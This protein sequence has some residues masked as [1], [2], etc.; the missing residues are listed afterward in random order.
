MKRRF[1]LLPLLAVF[2]CLGQANGAAPETEKDGAPLSIT[3]SVAKDSFEVGAP[4]EVTITLTN[5]G[6]TDVVWESERPDPAY[7]NFWFSLKVKDV[8]DIPT[9][10]YHRKIRGK[11]FPEDPI[12][13]QSGSSQFATLAAGHS[14]NFVIDLTKLYQL[15][16]PGTYTLVVGRDN[17]SNKAKL[18]CKPLEIRVVSRKEGLRAKHPR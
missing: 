13:V 18:Q 2:A 17:E 16:L 8:A 1:L 6:K 5:T 9:T 3:L 10:A 14:V 11:Q 4:I 15:E 7:R 12:A